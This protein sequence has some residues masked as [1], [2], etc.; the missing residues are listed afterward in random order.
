MEGFHLYKK[1]YFKL[2]S[3]DVIPLFDVY[4]LLLKHFIFKHGHMDPPTC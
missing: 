1:Y 3:I 2:T 4:D